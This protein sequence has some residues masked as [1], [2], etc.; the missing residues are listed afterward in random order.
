MSH[1]RNHGNCVLR[2][3]AW[4]GSTGGGMDNLNKPSYSSN[5]C[6]ALTKKIDIAL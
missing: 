1:D 3:T 5:Y 6:V 4:N 2:N